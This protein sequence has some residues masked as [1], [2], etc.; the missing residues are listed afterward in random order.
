VVMPDVPF[1]TI[2]ILLAPQSLVQLPLRHTQL[3]PQRYI[4][5]G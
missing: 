5:L 3:V 4:Q 2:V 1:N